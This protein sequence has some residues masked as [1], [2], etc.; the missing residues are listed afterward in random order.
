MAHILFLT[1]YYPPEVGAAQARISETAARLVARGHQVTV[2]TTL[3]N[4]PN[5]VVP[6][7]FQHGQR[8]IEERDGVRIVRVW[9]YITPNKGFLR[10]ILAQLSFGLLA[11]RLAGKRIG[12]PDV[13]IV[14]SPPLF[15]A[16]AG[17]MLARHFK[18]PYIFTVADIWPESAVQLGALRNKTA[19]RLAENLEW[20]TYQRS[21]AVW[22]VTEGIRQ[23]LIDRGLP[24]EKVFLLTNGVDTR[25]FH[26]MARD[27]ARAELGWDDR[28]TVMYAGT[29]GLAHGLQTVLGAAEQL[30]DHSD[31]RFMLIGAG[32][33]K[34]DLVA[35]AER[36]NL[37]NVTF[38][39]PQPHAMMP[40]ILN[41]ADA[42]VASL[43][44]IPLFAGALPSKMYEAMACA[45][46][47]LLAVEGEARRLVAEEAQ[48]A[49]W[50]PPESPTELAEAVLRLKNDP[51]LVARLGQN[52]RAF[53]EARF[54]RDLLTAALEKRIMALLG[55]VTE[56]QLLA[57]SNV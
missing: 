4:Y 22:A 12:T 9:S 16:Y 39:D 42:C 1:P 56:S 26:P 40:T 2:L 25:K 51:A 33:A 55:N 30:R 41:A 13:V 48:A 14:E 31:I 29:I 44:N 23:T 18:A 37:T 28:F 15:D 45:R 49:L 21:G 24:P 8:R 36:R 27:A 5:G 53:V 10:R 46:P 54:D 32:A 20:T 7:E 11:P 19:I 6:P 43:L 50:V 38:M 34:A 57:P 3:P 47:L 17:R 52:G 35:D